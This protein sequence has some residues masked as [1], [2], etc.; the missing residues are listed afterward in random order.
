MASF[1]APMAAAERSGERSQEQAAAE[2]EMHA[3]N[4]QY[5]LDRRAAL[6]KEAVIRQ[7][8][9]LAKQ[10]DFESSV[11]QLNEMRSSNKS[12]FGDASTS[13]ILA[14]MMLGGLM[15][16]GAGAMQMMNKL[17]D[18]NIAQQ[19][20]DWER[21]LDTMKGKQA[22]Y[23]L[24]MD[25]WK[26]AD[27]ADSMVRAASIDYMLEKV[28]EKTAE[29][30]GVAA[31]NHADEARAMLMSE[32]EKTTAN[33][34]KF[35]QASRVEPRYAMSIR[36]QMLPGT[37]SQADAQKYAVEHGI[38]PAEK[39]DEILTKG[40][41]DMVAKRA[42][43]ANKR[44]ERADEGAK[45]IATEMQKAGVPRLR[46]V[47]EQAL[48]ALNASPGGLG[49]AAVRGATRTALPLVGDAVGNALMS[50]KANE[51]ERAFTML[52]NL[53]FHELSGAAVSKPEEARL[54]RA[55]GG[56][57]PELRK[58]ALQQLLGYLDEIERNI[59][60]GVPPESQEKFDRQRDAAK[61]GRPAAPAGAKKG[62]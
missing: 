52:L 18:K 9:M 22:A 23:G 45:F 2:A 16:G 39:T 29:R 48:T 49:E 14:A 19:R 7:K 55:L 31:A 40:A 12:L 50:D 13:D 58:A 4:A 6:E 42:E 41:V 17:I 27:V 57:D 3:Q 44:S 21:G 28:N 25:R 38:K 8:E 36:G 51:R 53:N 32:R 26:D 30:G 15:G 24:A 1:D 60:G 43:L 54:K 33:A 47:A 46:M 20:F 11:K 61:A 59:K 5:F 34:Y 35:L 10:Q 62:W 56:S 37:L